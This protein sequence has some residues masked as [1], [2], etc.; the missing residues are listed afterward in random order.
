MHNP[1]DCRSAALNKYGHDVEVAATVA[2]NDDGISLNGGLERA[3]RAAIEAA[4]ILTDDRDD[5]GN[6]V[7][8]AVQVDYPFSQSET[9]ARFFKQQILVC[10]YDGC[11]RKLGYG[12][13]CGVGLRLLEACEG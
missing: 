2:Y 5:R 7:A 11:S 3:P 8:S 4:E 6:T 12:E 10:R 9:L 1:L 13:V